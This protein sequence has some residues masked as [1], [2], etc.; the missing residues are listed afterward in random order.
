LAFRN[1]VSLLIVGF[2]T[3][4]VAGP[5]MSSSSALARLS[6]ADTAAGIATVLRAVDALDR[7]DLPALEAQ[8]DS[9]DFTFS[10]QPIAAGRP[11]TSWPVIRASLSTYFDSTRRTQPRLGLTLTELR[12]SD[13][14]FVR[15]VYAHV[16]GGPIP[17]WWS[18]LVAGNAQRPWRI[19]LLYAVGEPAPSRHKHIPLRP[20]R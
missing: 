5:A 15:A 1:G 6:P 13:A 9:T 12:A 4:C 19:G 3:S 7:L 18:F 16:Q 2:A 10:F 11:M 8:L 17:G 14:G 20:P